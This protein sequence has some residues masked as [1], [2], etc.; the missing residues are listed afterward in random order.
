MT[1]KTLK[2][3]EKEHIQKVLDRTHWDL[4]KTANLL[5]I[6]ISQVKSKIRK[7]ELKRDSQYSV[8][9]NHKS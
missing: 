9:E 3:L 8:H 6:P 1:T 5:K 7:Y 2:E 4:E